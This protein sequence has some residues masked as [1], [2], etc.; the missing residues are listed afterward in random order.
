MNVE[1]QE[2][3]RQHVL[4]KDKLSKDKLIATLKSGLRANKDC[5]RRR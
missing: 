3:L 4:C 1:T 2:D 5:T